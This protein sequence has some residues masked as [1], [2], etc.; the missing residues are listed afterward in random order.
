MKNDLYLNLNKSAE[1][2]HERR[3]LDKAIHLVQDKQNI[4]HHNLIRVIPIATLTYA[5]NEM[6]ST[7]KTVEVEAL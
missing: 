2:V 1:L 4:K 7:A 6:K 3:H 5:Q